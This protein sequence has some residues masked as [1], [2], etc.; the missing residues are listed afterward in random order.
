M[1]LLA[2]YGITLDPSDEPETKN[3]SRQDERRTLRRV[4]KEFVNRQA[5]CFL[6]VESDDLFTRANISAV[7]DVAEAVE[8]LPFV[9]SALWLDAISV[10][11]DYGLPMNLVPHRD[12]LDGAIDEDYRIARKQALEHTLVKGQL[13][14]DDGQTLLILIGLDRSEMDD[15]IEAIKHLR[16]VAKEAAAGSAITVRLTGGMP[17][18]AIEREISDR[19]H[20]WHQ[21]LGYGIVFLIAVFV[22]R[23]LEAVLIV[24]SAPVLGVFWSLG[25]LGLMGEELDGLSGPILP[26]LIT[27]VG[28][29]D[30]VHLMIHIRE[31]RVQGFSPIEASRSAVEHI[32]LACF[33]TSLTTAIGFGSLML[34]QSEV[35]RD[36]GRACAVGVIATFFAVTIL[37]PLLSST[38]VGRNVHLGESHDFVGKHL[39]RMSGMIDAI[40][41]H[42]R[43]VTAIAVVITIV[44]AGIASTLRPDNKLENQ[45]P[46]R[47]EAY[48]ALKHCDDV[49][50]GISFVSVV[51]EWP[52]ST[53][54]ESPEFIALLDDVEALLAS[55]PLI[56]NP[57]SIK[58]VLRNMPTWTDDLVIRIPYLKS[59]P[60]AVTE[61]F[62][63]PDLRRALVIARVRDEGIA[64]YDP[65]FKRIEGELEELEQKHAGFELR[66]TGDPVVRGRD[67]SQI[68]SDLATSL[69]TATLII[70]CVMMI[71]YRSL[72]IGLISLVPN[73]LPLVVTATLLVAIG[74][75]LDLY[76]VCA[77]TICLGI[78]VD[79]T[80]HFLS[81]FQYEF[82][83]D[84]DT[85][86]A[87]HRSFL[88][89][90]RGIVTTTVVLVSGFAVV[91]SSELPGNVAFAAMACSTIAAALLGDLI[92]LPALLAL[93]MKPRPKL[94]DAEPVVPATEPARSAALGE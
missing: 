50:G 6:V 34:A 27:L 76:S 20:R 22:F 72:K 13:L 71:V 23:R 21:L 91:L 25:I 31:K 70:F 56:R 36:F 32:G 8:E 74:R 81:R 12:D 11:D 78:A 48:Q 60:E 93:F 5:D 73:L 26:I 40:V 15:R 43:L 86:A 55:E 67:L 47:S 24:G 59:L 37:I 38:R 14:S 80:I 64:R 29:T 42:A 52:E 39:Q 10:F 19:E 4:K 51:A 53:S 45:L 83:V 35:V 75:P 65:I 61:R 89:V 69:G 44:T 18:W 94:I 28:F 87:I 79:D 49:F 1:S 68:V 3:E 46:V 17:L 88:G 82:A 63:R 7:R 58:S 9:S 90:G 85:N 33:L 62:Y 30:G 41:R 92:F 2:G 66:L 84:G 57:V 77:F 16:K 54:A